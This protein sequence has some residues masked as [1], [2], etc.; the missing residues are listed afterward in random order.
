MGCAGSKDSPNNMCAQNVTNPYDQAKKKTNTNWW[1]LSPIP[2]TSDTTS[3]SRGT[4]QWIFQ[5]SK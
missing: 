4:P 3:T 1:M 5:R 2:P